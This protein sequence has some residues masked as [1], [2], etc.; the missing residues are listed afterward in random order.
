MIEKCSFCA[1]LET[2]DNPLLAAPDDAAFICKNCVLTAY[3]IIM[4]AQDKKK[5]KNKLAA[6][7]R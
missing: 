3:E 4:G 2:E 6:D 7:E 5:D 1:S